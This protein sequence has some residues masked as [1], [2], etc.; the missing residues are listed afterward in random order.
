[1]SVIKVKDLLVYIKKQLEFDPKLQQVYVGGEISEYKQYP[2]GHIYFTLKDQE[3]NARCVMWK[4]YT[5]NLNFT[6]KV[7]DRIIILAQPTIFEK[8]GSLQLIVYRIQMDG[9]GDLYVQFQKLKEQLYQQGYFDQQHK[10]VIP[11][12]PLRLCLVTGDNSA[13]YHDLVKTIQKRWPVCKVYHY[14]T[15]VQGQ[16]ADREI[17]NALAYCDLQKFDTIIL[18]RG[19]GSIE[20]LWCFNSV[21]L[22]K[23][24]F[25]LK[26]P[27]VTGVGHESDTTLVDYVADYAASTPTYAA[28]YATP[29]IH[30]VK[31][32]LV[33]RHSFLKHS[34]EQKLAKMRKTINTYRQLPLFTRSNYFIQEKSFRLDYLYQKLIY[35]TSTIELLR[36]SITFKQQMLINLYQQTMDF[37]RK[38]LNIDKQDL[39]NQILNIFTAY[40]TTLAQQIELMDAYSPLKVIKRGYSL[41]YSHQQLI[42]SVKDVS[43]DMVIETKLKDGSIVS[44]VKEITNDKIKF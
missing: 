15:L 23:C 7:G 38:K 24:I 44:L 9:I 40:K 28:M 19:G 13:A 34:I 5:N 42:K 29:E 18:A 14:P 1:M 25:E 31:K 2:S 20:D 35:Y 39:E 6:P 10:K 43:K 22:V 26:T 21:E 11:K 27:I 30:D 32:E 41:T 8:T 3:A 36:Q 33:V 16:K 4:N 12:Y 17:I 37:Y